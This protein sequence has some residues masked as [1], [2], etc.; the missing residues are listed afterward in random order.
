M[1]ESSQMIKSINSQG[2]YLTFRL[3]NEEYGLGIMMI[4]EIIG[5]MTITAIPQTPSYVKGVINLRGKVIPVVDL[6]LRFS[7]EEIPHDDRT[8]IIVADIGGEAADVLVGLIVDSVSEVMNI[9]PDKIEPPP[10]FGI[11]LDTDYILGIAKSDSDVRILLDIGR[12]FS[13]NEI[14]GFR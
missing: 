12:V 8:C 7:M 9:D 3:G 11:T 2:K 5:M 10:S 6:R 1:G 4:K 13:D 14:S